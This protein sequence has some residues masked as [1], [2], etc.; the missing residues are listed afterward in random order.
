MAP[1]A[2]IALAILAALCAQAV[3]YPSLWAGVSPNGFN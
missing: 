2:G 1:R 3:A